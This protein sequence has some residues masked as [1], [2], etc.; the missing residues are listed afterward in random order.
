MNA[1]GFTLSDKK[2]NE[3]EFIIGMDLSVLGIADLQGFA[4]E[5]LPV[6]SR[7]LLYANASRDICFVFKWNG[8]PDFD[9]NLSLSIRLFKH[10]CHHFQNSL[11][12][13]GM[14]GIVR[15]L[16]YP[17][18]GADNVDKFLMLPVID[19]EE[20]G[21]RSFVFSE[22][23][24]GPVILSGLDNCDPLRS[25]RLHPGPNGELKEVVLID[26]RDGILDVLGRS[27]MWPG[28]AL[29]GNIANKYM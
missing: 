25:K 9:S 5:R 15:E 21:K 19:H 20:V 4:L 27:G 24:M 17:T 8:V 13:C 26:G 12:R 3:F 16:K 1:I 29:E 6:N 7:V 2:Y 18:F 22:P 28:H 11:N 23:E 14:D 10:L